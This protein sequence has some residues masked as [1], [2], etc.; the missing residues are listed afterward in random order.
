MGHQEVQMKVYIAGP[1]SGIEDYNRPEFKRAEKLLKSLGF[2]T[3]NITDPCYI[4]VIKGMTE[5]KRWVKYMIR[6]LEI[7]LTCDAIYFIRKWQ[8][9]PGARIE[10]IVAERLG[11]F[12]FEERKVKQDKYMVC[13]IPPQPI[14]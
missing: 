12:I 2:E 14:K 1:I 3:I 10:R 7:L 13:F 9:S 8:E 5:P 4:G 11:L 6:D